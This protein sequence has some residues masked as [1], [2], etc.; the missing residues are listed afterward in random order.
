MSLPA[1]ASAAPPDTVYFP[2][3]DGTELVGYLFHP[4]GNA[5][6]QRHPAIVMLHGRGGPYSSN[7]NAAC[8]RIG[9][10]ISSPCNTGTLSQR[11]KMWG[12]YWAARGY[13]A[14][15]VDSF[16]PRGR[17]HGYGRNSHDLP[18][19]QAVNELTVRPLDAEAALAYLA[20][21][22]DVRK[23]SIMLQGWSNGGSTALNVMYRQA[24][25][26]SSFAAARFR[27]ALVFYPGCG[28]RA[29]LSRRYRSDTD[30][31]VFLASND[32][33][34]SPRNCLRA[35]QANNE[36]GKVKVIEYAGAMHD[37]DDPGRARQ[38][39]PENRAAKEDAMRRAALL[40]EE[41]SNSANRPAVPDN[42]K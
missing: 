34:V 9:R 24:Q 12:E 31:L 21:R 3:G 25:G 14:L 30:V 4:P 19:R 2:G 22:D 26:N 39:V 35:L 16:G 17:A 29:L 27:A 36:P 13:L 5:G 15:H 42:R 7:V 40:L 11:H 8:S 38:S 6:Q 33:E 23:D 41:F 20:A 32:E 1:T 28:A 10:D 18:E 37:F